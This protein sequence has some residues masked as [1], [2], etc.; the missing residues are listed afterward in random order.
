[1]AGSAEIDPGEVIHAKAVAAPSH[2]TVELPPPESD[3]GGT[4][5]ILDHLTQGYAADPISE[6]VPDTVRRHGADDILRILHD[7]DAILAPQRTSMLDP[8]EL[9][10]Q[11]IDSGAITCSSG[12]LFCILYD[13]I[14]NAAAALDD[15]I[16]PRIEVFMVEHQDRVFFQV[17]DNGHGFSTQA[18][19]NLICDCDGTLRW[20]GQSQSG[21]SRIID[22]VGGL[23]GHLRLIHTSQSGAR[24]G[25][26]LAQSPNPHS[27]RKTIADFLAALSSDPVHMSTRSDRGADMSVHPQ[28]KAGP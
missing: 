9:R 13:L 26:A 1:M 19:S 27:S 14:S 18:L 23:G 24:L 28:C 21:L 22:L 5:P 8:F 20:R 3:F 6:I 2:A 11:T 4:R 12:G 10:L 25:V 17:G 15:R 16:D 7:V